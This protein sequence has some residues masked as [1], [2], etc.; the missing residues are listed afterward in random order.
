MAGPGGCGGRVF[1]DGGGDC[2]LVSGSNLAT[3]VPKIRIRA[4]SVLV[5]EISSLYRAYCNAE[6]APR[7]ANGIVTSTLTSVSSQAVT[8]VTCT[9]RLGSFKADCAVE[10]AEPT[11]RS[12]AAAC[13]TLSALA[14]KRM[15][16]LSA[17]AW[18]KCRWVIGGNKTSKTSCD[19]CTP[20]AAASTAETTLNA[21]PT[22]LITPGTINS[23]VKF[24]RSHLASKKFTFLVSIDST[25][26]STTLKMSSSDN[27]LLLNCKTDVT[28]NNL[29]V[30]GVPK[31]GGG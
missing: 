16:V 11:A 18:S 9:P 6:T 26:A 31:G 7:S 30:G 21:G 28:N 13:E 29:G 3:T 12:S 27:R 17:A 20:A 24:A 8:P 23:P 1:E 25:I 22:V 5:V 2:T 4:I 10:F 14:T 15:R 19:G